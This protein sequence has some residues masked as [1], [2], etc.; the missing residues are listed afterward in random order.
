M[1]SIKGE[2]HTNTQH[3][4]E[5]M[6]P[7][8]SLLSLMDTGGQT[9]QKRHIES[10]VKKVTASLSAFYNVVNTLGWFIE[11][12]SFQKIED[13]SLNPIFEE[14]AS[15]NTRVTIACLTLA[16]EL[17]SWKDAFVP[18]KEH[19]LSESLIAALKEVDASVREEN[20]EGVLPNL[21]QAW[22]VAT[23]SSNFGAPPETA[24]GDQQQQRPPASRTQSVKSDATPLSGDSEM[25]P[26]PEDVVQARRDAEAMPP[27]RRPSIWMQSYFHWK[28]MFDRNEAMIKEARRHFRAKLKQSKDGRNLSAGAEGYVVDPFKQKQ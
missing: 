7:N 4:K 27:P 11:F 23:K 10:D 26:T 1:C 9:P 25:A 20:E 21:A 8:L 18:S 2:K 6:L 12:E 5:A 22:T 16:L 13:P 14:A 24:D 19:F 17:E 28:D 3:T 15:T